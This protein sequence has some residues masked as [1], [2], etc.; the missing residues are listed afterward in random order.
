MSLVLPLLGAICFVSS[1]AYPYP[2]RREIQP[3]LLNHFV[4]FAQYSVASSCTVN[5][6]ISTGEHPVY[7]DEAYCS[8]LKA[9]NTEVL[10]AFQDIFPGDTAGFIAVDHTDDLL[11]LSFR[12]TVSKANGQTDMGYLQ[13][14]ASTACQGCKAH[15]GFWTAIGAALINL[16]RA[17]EDARARYP[18]HR[19]VLTG[20]SLG[21]ALATLYAVLLRVRGVYVDLYTFGAPSVRNRAFARAITT[22]WQGLGANY[23]VTHADDKTPKILYRASR[24]AVAGLVV[25]E[26]SQSSPEN[27]ITSGN[28][29]SVSIQD[30]QVIEGVNNE[31]GNLGRDWGNIR[32]HS[33][34]FGGY[35]SMCGSIACLANDPGTV[36]KGVWGN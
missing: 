22:E 15:A 28:G 36:P 33:W 25:P 32:D 29:E 23:R 21:G 10:Y 11:V 18:S 1:I 16:S 13:V 24:A 30:V 4:L 31:A 19:L 3:S 27:W 17:L 5:H 34:Y 6:N 20:H 14:D 8:L 12:D 2:S 35:Q 9:A 26:Y 7:C